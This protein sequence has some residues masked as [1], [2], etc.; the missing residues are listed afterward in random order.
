MDALGC[1]YR[2]SSLL[3]IAVSAIQAGHFHVAE[4]C[5]AQANEW[6]TDGRAS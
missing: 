1:A 5:V 3:T 2:A 6:I 4:E